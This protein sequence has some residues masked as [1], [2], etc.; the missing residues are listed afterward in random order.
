M[1]ETEILRQALK[2]ISNLD[3]KIDKLQGSVH[4]V[5]ISVR[6]M[7]VEKK[8]TKEQMEKMQAEIKENKETCEKCPARR[9]YESYGVMIRDGGLLFALMA[10]FWPKIEK[11]LLYLVSKS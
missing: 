2:T 6:E 9:R 3:E 8:Y 1:T 10:P 11:V 4:E 7:S 5:A